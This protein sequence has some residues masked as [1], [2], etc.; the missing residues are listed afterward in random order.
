MEKEDR[1]AEFIG[2]MLGDG[3][4][5][6]Y[7]C[8]FKNKIKKQ[9]QLKVT[10][11]S[12]N[13]DYIYYVS[14][15]MKEV[16]EVDPVVYFK[17]NENTADI[18]TFKKE[19]VEFALN[20]LGLKKSPKWEKMEIPNEYAKGKLALY[21]LRGLFDTDGS[22]TVFNNNGIIYPRIEIRICPSPA[23]SQ[24]IEILNNNKFN[25]KIQHLDKGKIKIRISGKKEVQR[26]FKEVGSSN[27][28]YIKRAEPFL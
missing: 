2:I 17:K 6:V 21:V 3:C 22:V 4:I 27:S 13:K 19:K 12:R 15:L 11:D 16:L 5:G 20:T 7:D 28:L 1:I 8:N 9:Y 14:T 26:W 24:I 18:R 23:K 25:Y 10:L